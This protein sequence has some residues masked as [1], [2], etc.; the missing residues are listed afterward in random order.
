MTCLKN[1]ELDAQQCKII[2]MN[3]SKMPKKMVFFIKQQNILVTRRDELSLAGAKGL[4]DL[5]RAEIG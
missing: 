3:N 2:G 1:E 5:K 4:C